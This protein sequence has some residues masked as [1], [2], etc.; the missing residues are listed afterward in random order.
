MSG[1]HDSGDKR[2]ASKC[3]PTVQVPYTGFPRLKTRLHQGVSLSQHLASIGRAGRARS[4]KQPALLQIADWRQRVSSC[5][6]WKSK[7]GM[8]K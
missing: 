3:P 1:I 7:R 2:V 4:K 6:V 5:C 8:A